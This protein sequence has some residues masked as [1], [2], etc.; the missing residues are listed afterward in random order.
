MR[1]FGALCEA[2]IQIRVDGYR[3][4]TVVPDV[5]PPPA[6]KQVVL[7]VCVAAAAG[8]PHLFLTESVIE[9]DHG[10][11]LLKGLVYPQSVIGQYRPVRSER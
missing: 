10:P 5:L 7:K 4:P 1:F 9:L 2:P 6:G 11:Y 3:R 8:N